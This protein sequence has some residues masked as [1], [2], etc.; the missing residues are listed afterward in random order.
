VQAWAGGNY[1][2]QTKTHTFAHTFHVNKRLQINT[3]L[4]VFFS[5]G[6]GFNAHIQDTISSANAAGMV[7]FSLSL[8]TTRK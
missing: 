5:V 6:F 1:L 4:I 3:I 2:N 7:R 8:H